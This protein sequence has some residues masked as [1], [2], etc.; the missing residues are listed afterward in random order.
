MNSPK[1]NIGDIV[2]LKTSGKDMVVKENISSDAGFYVIVT[3]EKDG[4]FIEKEFHED[5]LEKRP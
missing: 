5:M 2:Y 3:W 1:F 4:E